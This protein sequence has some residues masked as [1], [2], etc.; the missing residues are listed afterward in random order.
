MKIDYLVQSIEADDIR[1][2]LCVVYVKCY[3]YSKLGKALNHLEDV[4]D[5]VLNDG[6]IRCEYKSKYNY[7][8]TKGL[9]VE[10]LKA[11]P[12]VNWGD[13]EGL[14]KRFYKWM[15]WYRE[16]C[17][18]NGQWQVYTDRWKGVKL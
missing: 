3:S 15:E 2:F 4:F 5:E 14:D 1:R 6:E 18:L 8:I 11:N 12:V 10:F 17:E 13:K 9:V 16:M 7:F